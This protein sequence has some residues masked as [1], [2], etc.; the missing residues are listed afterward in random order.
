MNDLDVTCGD[1]KFT[2][3]S[4]PMSEKHYILLRPKFGDDT[5]KYAFIVRALYGGKHAGQ[6]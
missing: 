2:Y 6:D 3:L 5:G 4:A 1:V